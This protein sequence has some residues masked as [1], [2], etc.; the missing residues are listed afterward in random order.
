MDWRMWIDIYCAIN[1]QY[2]CTSFYCDGTKSSNS[3]GATSRE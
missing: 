1:T 3:G 2:H